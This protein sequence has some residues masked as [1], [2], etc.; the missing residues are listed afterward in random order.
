[1]ILFDFIGQCPAGWTSVDGQCEKT[2]YIRSTWPQAVKACEGHGGTLAS[3]DD[4]S[5]NS[6]IS[7][8]FS[9]SFGNL[10]VGITGNG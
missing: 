9:L 4:I 6:L 1:M 5:K 2:F 8:F 3:Q 7:S 10:W